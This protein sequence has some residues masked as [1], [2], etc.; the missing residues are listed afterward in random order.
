MRLILAVCAATLFATPAF[1][2]PTPSNG[3][4]LSGRPVIEREDQPGIVKYGNEDGGM[5]AAIAEAR[6]R[7]PYFWERMARPAAA[8]QAFTLKVAFPVVSENTAREHI[9][10]DSVRRDG[11][12]FKGALANEP[13]WMTGK[14]VGDEVA[15]TEDMISDWGFARRGKLI[16]YYTL[17]VML[18]DMPPEE[19]N[20]YEA[21]LGKNPD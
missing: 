8:E 13:N 6:E 18:D 4:S 14:R 7:L 17:R 2:Q 15:F 3:K 19:R 20:M 11:D 21:M 10:V 1:A 5:N 16:G 9:W 12:A